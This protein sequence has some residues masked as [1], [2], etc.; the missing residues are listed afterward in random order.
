MTVTV[1]VAVLLP[2]LAVMTATPTPHA[3]TMP[4]DTVATDRLDDDHVISSVALA[5]CSVASNVSLRPT[6]R[7]RDV[8]SKLTPVAGT[9]IVVNSYILEVVTLLPLLT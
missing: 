9:A 2:A 1:H 4:S 6:M 5:G 3:V 8:L 7:V